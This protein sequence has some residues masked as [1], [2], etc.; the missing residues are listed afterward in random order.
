MVQV[1]FEKRAMNDAKMALNDE[2]CG[3]RGALKQ[4][5]KRERKGK[6][7]LQQ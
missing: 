5:T 4:E 7:F 1:E 3:V 6:L 2:S